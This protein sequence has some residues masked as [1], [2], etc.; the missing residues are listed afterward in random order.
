MKFP[1]SQNYVFLYIS[2]NKIRFAVEIL[3]MD[4]LRIFNFILVNIVTLLVSQR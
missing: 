4:Y 1:K 3:Q 2:D